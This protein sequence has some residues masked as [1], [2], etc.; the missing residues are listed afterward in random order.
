M[1][2][3]G[4]GLFHALRKGSEGPPIGQ[5]TY[6]VLRSMNGFKKKG[7]AAIPQAFSRWVSRI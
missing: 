3:T 5:R 2:R 4:H 6:W 1:T 7:R